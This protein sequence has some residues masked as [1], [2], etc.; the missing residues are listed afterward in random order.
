MEVSLPVWSLKP[1]WKGGVLER[2]SWLTDVMSSSTGFEQRRALRISPR[3][4]L[5]LTVT[6]VK[7][8]RAF[9]DLLL[10]RLGSNDWLLPIWYDKAALMVPAL[11][12]ETRVE[13]DNT[14]REHQA[15]KL[16]ILHKGTHQWEVISVSSGDDTG[17][18]LAAPLDN[19]WPVGTHVYPLRKARLQNET[20]LD[21][22][23]SRVGESVLLWDVIE[24]GDD[25]S[26]IAGLPVFEGSPVLAVPPNRS[27]KLTTAHTRLAYDLDNRTGIPHRVDSVGRA[28]QVQSH[29]WLLRGRENQAVFKALLHG[30]GGRRR[31]V[32]LPSF[33]EDVQASRAAVESAEHLDIW[34]I[35]MGYAGGGQTIPGRDVLFISGNAARVTAVGGTPSTAE[36]R[37]VIG[38][39]LPS[40][41]AAGSYGSFLSLARLNQDEIEILHHADSAGVME[42]SATFKTFADPGS[43]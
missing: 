11:A 31:A 41:V 35:G 1:N 43:A 21:A 28:F 2:L 13:F 25:T 10:H 3:Q 42:C 8:D 29:S 4:S 23:S 22:L 36:E 39:G 15:G 14:F 26:A 27:S 40:D 20:S 19:N 37:L 5:E 33:N 24:A 6:P 30:L 9:V 7:S 16:A 32:W 34:A 17:L 12:G 38:A 18:S